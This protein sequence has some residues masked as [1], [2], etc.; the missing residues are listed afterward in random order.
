V[1]GNNYTAT[2]S[3]FKEQTSLAPSIYF[4]FLNPLSPAQSES[5]W[6]TALF[7]VVIVLILNLASRLIAAWLRRE[8]H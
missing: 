3:P 7:L 8:R 4:N 2:L 6:G 1:I 5:A